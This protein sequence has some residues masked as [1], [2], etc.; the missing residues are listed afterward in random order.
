MEDE[1]PINFSFK[2]AAAF[3]P[4]V[5]NPPAVVPSKQASDH[6]STS[7][8]RIPVVNQGRSFFP[9][10][11]PQVPVLQN[12]SASGS[13]GGLSTLDSG[14]KGELMGVGAALMNVDGETNEDQ[15]SFDG[16]SYRS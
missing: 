15:V 14:R 3:Q 7:V 6:G 11:E 16:I 12:V 5:S 2:K 8:A 4:I 13:G 1:I 10:G 9:R